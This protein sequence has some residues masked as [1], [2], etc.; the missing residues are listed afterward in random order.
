[1]QAERGASTPE[2]PGPL[3]ERFPSTQLAATVTLM[4][5]ERGNENLII[6]AKP[7]EALTASDAG[8]IAYLMHQCYSE[9]WSCIQKEAI[10]ALFSAK[11][12]LLLGIRNQGVL[13]AFG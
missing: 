6:T 10:E 5:L 2:L 3:I 11:E 4:R 7:P 1:M 13:V 8:D 9:M 12:S